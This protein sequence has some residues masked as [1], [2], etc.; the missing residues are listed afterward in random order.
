M[1]CVPFG[2]ILVWSETLW[3]FGKSSNYLRFSH[4]VLAYNKLAYYKLTL[5]KRAY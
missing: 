5:Y 2:L 3:V 1:A 4:S